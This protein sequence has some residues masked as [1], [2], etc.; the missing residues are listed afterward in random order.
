MANFLQ[1]A[2]TNADAIAYSGLH[3]LRTE[4]SWSRVM[5]PELQIAVM[6][7][8]DGVTIYI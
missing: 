6:D 5:V 3:R 1:L 7:L 4:Q 8:A 2:T